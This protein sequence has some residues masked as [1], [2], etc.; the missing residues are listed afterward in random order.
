MVLRMRIEAY[1]ITV[2]NT[3]YIQVIWSVGSMFIINVLLCVADRCR[4]V[5]VVVVLC[6]YNKKIND[7][8]QHTTIETTIFCE[9]FFTVI[10]I[11]GVSFDCHTRSGTRTCFTLPSDTA[12]SNNTCK[13]ERS[14]QYR[15][16]RG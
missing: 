12:V 10:V 2:K 8:C 15:L 7:N 16:A 11:Y 14:G 4:W 1:K 9:L 13:K 5:A 3:M 6:L